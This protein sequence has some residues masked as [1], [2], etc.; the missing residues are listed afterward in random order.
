MLA[1]GTTRLIKVAQEHLLKASSALKR[2]LTVPVQSEATN[3][4]IRS[5]D[6]PHRDP[7]T[8]SERK[9]TNRPSTS[10]ARAWQITPTKR[11]DDQP[12]E[13]TGTIRPR[14]PSIIV[15]AGP[16]VRPPALN[17]NVVPPARG[18]SLIV[19]STHANLPFP[20]EFAAPLPF[21]SAWADHHHLHQDPLGPLSLPPTLPTLTPHSSLISP[22]SST[23]ANLAPGPSCHRKE[24]KRNKKDV[25]KEGD[26]ETISPERIYERLVSP[27][28]GPYT[29][30]GDMS[31]ELGPELS[32]PVIAE[33]KVEFTSLKRK[34]RSDPTSPP[35]SFKRRKTSGPGKDVVEKER[36]KNFHLTIVVKR[37]AG[38]RRSGEESSDIAG[39]PVNVERDF[40]RHSHAEDP[41]VGKA[42]AAGSSTVRA[43]DTFTPVTPSSTLSQTPAEEVNLLAQQM[44]SETSRL[45]FP[46]PNNS[47]CSPDHT[48]FRVLAQAA[49]LQRGFSLYVVHEKRSSIRSSQ[50][51]L[52]CTRARHSSTAK[53]RFSIVVQRKGNSELEIWSCVQVLGKHNH[54]VAE[55]DEMGFLRTESGEECEGKGKA[56]ENVVSTSSAPRVAEFPDHTYPLLLPQSLGPPNTVTWKKPD[57]TL[58]DISDFPLQLRLNLRN[59]KPKGHHLAEYTS[60]F[61]SRGII[62]GAALRGL[63]ML[64]ENDLRVWLDTLEKD[65][66]GA[67]GQVEHSGVPSVLVR[68]FLVPAL[69]EWRKSI[70]I[71]SVDE[72]K[73]VKR[74]RRNSW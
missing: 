20:P 7:R 14:A 15:S 49:A 50:F 56:R 64:S 35:P 6:M 3:T 73:W 47:I 22:T 41:D 28:L 43:R 21:S 62:S 51:R 26:E 42:L 48:T 5:H 32:L 40:D 71:T 23:L 18:E 9:L 19:S 10:R 36:K 16:Y 38:K 11:V 29:F 2:A 59:I 30:E 68:F 69:E 70:H 13:Y 12:N 46:L 53:C 52:T 25:A 55:D 37:R 8:D 65:V 27:E 60:N 67:D 1:S 66:L 74:K 58:L 39:Q 44:S 45:Q 33:S 34:T 24:K 31:P 72:C 61:L 17:T 57:F 63:L 54:D 4:Q